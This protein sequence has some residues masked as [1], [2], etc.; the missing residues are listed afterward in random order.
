MC[1]RR[2]ESEVLTRGKGTGKPSAP[3]S[4]A[5]AKYRR[6]M[7]CTMRREIL[8]VCATTCVRAHAGS[9]SGTESH[10]S[11]D[12]DLPRDERPTNIRYS[13]VEFTGLVQVQMSPQGRTLRRHSN[14]RT[15]DGERLFSD[16]RC[17]EAGIPRRGDKAE[18]GDQGCPGTPAEFCCALKPNL[19]ALHGALAPSGGGAIADMDDAYAYGP[20]DD[21]FPALEEFALS[22]RNDLG[23]EVVFTKMVCHST[24]E[25][26]RL[27]A[28][29][30]RRRLLLS[31]ARDQLSGL[32]LERGEEGLA[33]GTWAVA[34]LDG[35]VPG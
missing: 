26:E 3:R 4:L 33:A 22:V 32:R 18:G 16:E 6:H 19:D 23:M 24:G 29:A 7:I 11:R 28:S 25:S 13:V 14:R 31:L 12:L 34:V 17:D 2:T 27:Q 8:L 35:A 30:E 5:S 9:A 15:Q 10:R 21:V 1:T 20:I